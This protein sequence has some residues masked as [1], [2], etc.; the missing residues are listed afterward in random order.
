MRAILCERKAAYIGGVQSA[1]ATSQIKKKQ[2][3][4]AIT[5]KGHFMF[6]EDSGY[7][8]GVQSTVTTSSSPHSQCPKGNTFHAIA[9]L[10]ITIASCVYIYIYIYR[11][12]ARLTI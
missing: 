10:N 7:L 8:G 2:E 1:V 12:R 11:A 9:E 5:S 6:E 4:N 3:G